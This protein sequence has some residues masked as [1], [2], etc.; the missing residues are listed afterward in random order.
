MCMAHSIHRCWHHGTV[1]EAAACDT[2]TPERCASLNPVCSASGLAPWKAMKGNPNPSTWTPALCGIHDK[3]LGLGL[4][5][6]PSG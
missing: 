6:K 3:I 2:S 5:Q 1:G 4:A